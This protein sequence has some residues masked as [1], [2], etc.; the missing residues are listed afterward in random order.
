MASDGNYQF[1]TLKLVLSEVVENPPSTTQEVRNLIVGYLRQNKEELMEMQKIGFDY[2]DADFK[3]SALK[4][5]GEYGFDTYCKLMLNPSGVK[6]TCEW[7][8]TLTL[9]AARGL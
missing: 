1:K 3:A 4:A 8:D 6:A 2:G 9:I 7:G 5:Y